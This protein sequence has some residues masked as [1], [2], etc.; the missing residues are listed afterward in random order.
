MTKLE[1]II[2]D[3]DEATYH[4]RPE[5]SSTEA[6]LL[7]DSPAKY[8][9]RKDNPP[10]ID[11]IPAFTVGK[12]V[13]SLVLG[14]GDHPEIIPTELLASNG[15]VS[16]KAA[17]EWVAE[18]ETA[19]RTWMKADAYQLVIGCAE[20][21]LGNPDARELFDRPGDSEVSLFA[22]V[23]EVACRCRFDFLP[24]AGAGRRIAVDLKTTRDANP[25]GTHGFVSSL[26]KY[27][28]A[29]Q[30]AFYLD[31]LKQVTG[32]DAELV[33]V[34]VEPEPPYLLSVVQ[35][36]AQWR[37][38]GHAKAYL[39]RELW[40]R[41]TA[42]DEWPAWVDYKGGVTQVEAPTWYVLDWEAPEGDI[43]V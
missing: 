26:A 23:D 38:I 33:W 9:W 19:G 20:A 42:A 8:R 24:A 3:L 27:E 21:V 25:T 7:L 13:H 43:N 18:V 6:R 5:L 30:R 37:E 34:A 2:R 28:Y 15:A 17:K 40:A 29:V 35:L 31:I 1:G 41:C 10:L 36:G 4:A 39:A 22:E 32:E 14:A 11:P 12:A 16:T